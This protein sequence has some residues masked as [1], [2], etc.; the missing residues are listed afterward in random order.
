MAAT[1]PSSVSFDG[2]GHGDLDA[3]LVHSQ[4]LFH[5]KEFARCALV[6]STTSQNS[7]SSALTSRKEFLRG[8]ALLLALD[9]RDSLDS[10][11]ASKPV[12]VDWPLPV[13]ASALLADIDTRIAAARKG[14]RT[15]GFLLYL[16]ALVC[17]R[18]KLRDRAYASLIDALNAEPF[19]YAAWEELATHI[20]SIPQLNAALASLH[21]SSAKAPN[22]CLHSFIFQSKTNLTTLPEAAHELV[23]LHKSLGISTHASHPSTAPFS[24]SS[25]GTS[26]HWNTAIPP[27]LQ[28]A[29]ASMHYSHQDFPAAV[30]LFDHVYARNPATLD[31][32]DEFANALYVLE[33]HARLSHLAHAC[34]AL[35]ALRPETCVVVANYYS[36]RRE[37]EKAVAYLRRAVVLDQGYSLPWTLIGHEY[38][39]MKRNEAAV[40]VYRR[41]IDINDRDYRAWHGLGY[42]YQILKMPQYALFYYQKATAL[43]PNDPRFWCSLASCYED[44]K[45]YPNAVKAY[46]RAIIVECNL[47]QTQAAYGG[48]SLVPQFAGGGSSGAMLKVA[49]LYE[50][51]AGAGSGV[52]GGLE[53]L[54]PGGAMAAANSAAACFRQVFDAGRLVNDSNQ[55]TH[56]DMVEAAEYL[57]RHAISTNNFNDE[58]LP[59]YFDTL[60]E[61]EDGKALVRECRAT[62]LA[63]NK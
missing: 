22:P 41:A 24:S 35:D 23:A 8:F 38:V 45:D 20:H 1:G 44:V 12:R 5:M 9:G 19:L 46:K 48:A 29:E 53:A 18:V 40:E 26:I 37:K 30:A 7:A 10:D 61:S 13:T 49:R 34:T 31:R 39:E 4:S 57:V 16:H 52:A 54:G 28:L 55:A 58:G 27:S 43:R 2:E 47:Y 17:K 32:V 14:G 62:M 59:A 15:D 50:K 63:L 11:T 21:A 60:D 3:Q 36:L 51:L 6:L 25:S 56:D 42:L 33:D